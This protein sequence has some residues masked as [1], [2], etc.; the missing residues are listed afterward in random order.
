[1]S[2]VGMASKDAAL[3]YRVTWDPKDF[4]WRQRQP[5]DVPATTDSLRSLSVYLNAE[6]IP[7]DAKFKV[8]IVP[9]HCFSL[10]VNHKNLQSADFCELLRRCKTPGLQLVSIVFNSHI[11]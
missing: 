11:V 7:N 8:T 3:N 9:T 4:S 6:D 10:V 5:L 2:A 1:M